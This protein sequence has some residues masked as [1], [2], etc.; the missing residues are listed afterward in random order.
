MTSLEKQVRDFGLMWEG[1]QNFAQFAFNVSRL[2]LAAPARLYMC[3]LFTARRRDSGLP[4]VGDLFRGVTHVQTK[5]GSLYATLELRSSSSDTR[6]LLGATALWQSDR[7]PCWEVWTVAPR[8]VWNRAVLSAIGRTDGAVK[9]SLRQAQLAS[10]LHEFEARLVK[11]SLKGKRFASRQWVAAKGEPRRVGARVD[12]KLMSLDEVLAEVREQGEWLSNMS[13]ELMRLLDDGR[14]IPTGVHT[15]ISRRGFIQANRPYSELFS[16]LSL[17]LMRAGKDTIDRYS[18]RGRESVP[19]HAVRPIAIEYDYPIFREP[20]N[21]RDFIKAAKSVPRFGYSVIH[22]NPYI[23]LSL[24]DS[25]DGS[26]YEFFV[27]DEVRA[28]VV[29]QI[30]ATPGSLDRLLSHV[31]A[32]FPEGNLAELSET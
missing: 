22:S 20:S 28:I 1:S 23:H 14:R 29:P 27:F 6:R 10:V 16:E 12:W 17:L 24:T 11:M 2:E 3:P 19:K 7:V 32:V 4:P 9:P 25:S 18:N 30:R 15:G 21:C 31:F 13:F 8:E 5:D 26:S